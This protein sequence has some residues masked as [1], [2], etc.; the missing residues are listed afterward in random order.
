MPTRPPTHRAFTLQRRDASESPRLRGRHGVE[1]RQRLMRANPLCVECLKIGEYR[2]AV[3]FDHVVPLA[4]GGAD[5]ESNMQGLCLDC[6]RRKTAIEQQRRIASR[7]RQAEEIVASQS[8]ARLVID[9]RT[10]EAI[11]VAGE[12]RGG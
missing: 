1:R 7:V 10:G 9:P 8:E 11:V 2:E 6:H 3:E 5:H 4:D 12:S